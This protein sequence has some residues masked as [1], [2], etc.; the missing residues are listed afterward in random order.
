MAPEMLD[1]YLQGDDSEQEYSN[2]IDIWSLCESFY[3]LCLKDLP[4]SGTFQNAAQ[5]KCDF[6]ELPPEYSS[7]FKTMLISGLKFS[8]DERT[9]AKELYQQCLLGL[10]DEEDLGPPEVEVSIYPINVQI[11]NDS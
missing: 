11:P 6:P 3:H 10:D 5:G 4:K 9:S 7:D 8:A 1:K 2:K